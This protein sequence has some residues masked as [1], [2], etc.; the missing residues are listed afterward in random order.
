MTD[1]AH[2]P[3]YSIVIPCY[4]SGRWLGELVERID[5]TMD[6][7]GEDYEIVLVNDASD[8]AT[9]PEIERLASNR[10]YLRGIDLLFNVG[11]QRATICGIEHARGELILT[12][13]DDLQHPPE[14]IPKLIE[15]FESTP[16]IDCVMGT[17]ETL[18]QKWYRRL[19]T[20]LSAYVNQWFYGKPRELKMSAF[21]L[22]NRTTAEAICAHR[23]SRPII[24]PLLLMC[25]PRIV[26]VTVAHQFRPH[27]HSGYTL[28]R[29][30]RTMMDNVIAGTAVPLKAASLLGF[31]SAAGSAVLGIAYLVGWLVGAIGVPGFASLALLIVFFGGMTLMSVGLLGEYVIRIIHETSRP[32]RYFVRRETD[33][34]GTPQELSKSE[35]AA[36]TTS[37]KNLPAVP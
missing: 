34:G 23:T 32:P 6:R 8:D 35:S 28:L 18:R 16:G 31:L 36:H 11:Q 37:D 5:A 13:D 1:S 33:G 26:N 12:I 4:R 22:M 2:R 15:T 30:I 14:E 3:R 19:G 29:L 25:T 20:A 21:R 9:W 24:G 17:F 7:V 27:G 10:P